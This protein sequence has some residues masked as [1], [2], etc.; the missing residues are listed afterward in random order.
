MTRYDYSAADVIRNARARL[1]N[2]VTTLAALQERYSG[3]EG[4]GVA[5]TVRGEICALEADLADHLSAIGGDQWQYEDGRP[6]V[7]TVRVTGD[8]KGIAYVWDPR[9]DHPTNRPHEVCSI[10]LE[11]G[12]AATVVIAAV[13]VL[14]VVRMPP[15]NVV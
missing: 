9:L 4:A 5:E 7:S 3:S 10:R 11:D 15:S 12:T 14:D 13:G 6:V 2:I 1:R 8:G